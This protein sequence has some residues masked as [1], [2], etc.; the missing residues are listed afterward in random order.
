MNARLLTLR[1]G[2]IE[3]GIRLT[4]VDQVRKLNFSAGSFAEFLENFDDSVLT[5]QSDHINVIFHELDSRMV[6]FADTAA[7]VKNHNGNSANE[8]A[9]ASPDEHPNR[10]SQN[11]SRQE[12]EEGRKKRKR[13]KKTPRGRSLKRRHYSISKAAR[14][15]RDEASPI[16]PEPG[17]RSPSPVIDF[18]GLSR[19]S[20]YLHSVHSSRVSLNM[21]Y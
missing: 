9:I 17:T 18:D 6:N 12:D 11:D 15:P 2:G 16:E 4:R 7:E 5:P 20:K 19:P 13:D 1:V 8:S 10:T 14:D 3:S 21:V